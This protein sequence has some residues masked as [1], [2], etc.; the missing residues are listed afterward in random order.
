M[1]FLWSFMVLTL[2]QPGVAARTI[3]LRQW[4]HEA[5]WTGLFL[6]IVLNELFF[7]A[8]GLYV[9]KSSDL[10]MFGLSPKHPGLSLFLSALRSVGFAALLTYCGRLIGGTARFMPMLSL[11]VWDQLVQ[12]VVMAGGI[13]ALL[14][15]P[16]FGS[17][18]FLVIGLV[19]FFVLLNF[20]NEAHGFASLWYAF[21][22]VLMATIVLFFSMLFLD[23]LFGP[24]NT[25]LPTNV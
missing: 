10:A 16:T 20:V 15:S 23:G 14:A 1:S 19:M 2:R 4:P 22:V 13:A 18:V 6:A 7:G 12:L 17:I 11:L 24:A 9:T 5:I 25:G 3:L 8:L 21:A